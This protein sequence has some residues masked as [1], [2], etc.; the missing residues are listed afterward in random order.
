MGE[1]GFA[2]GRAKE[3]V[4]SD[5]E[6]VS[7]RHLACSAAFSCAQVAAGNTYE[8]TA[9]WYMYGSLTMKADPSIGLRHLMLT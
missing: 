7:S 5:Y 1:K 6:N 9:R 2:D 3:A 8:P 4:A